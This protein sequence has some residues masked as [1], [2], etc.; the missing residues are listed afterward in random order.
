MARRVATFTGL[1]SPGSITI[2]G[3]KAGDKV[4]AVIRDD[5]SNFSQDFAPFIATDG[6]LLQ[7]NP[8][9]GTDQNFVVLLD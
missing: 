4:Y 7:T 6:T 8:V 2:S 9:T 5:G 1:S 3:A